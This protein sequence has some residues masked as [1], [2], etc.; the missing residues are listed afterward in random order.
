MKRRRLVAAGVG[1]CVV[2]WFALQLFGSLFLFLARHRCCGAA[3]GN[4]C[5]HGIGGVDQARPGVH[6]QIW[7]VF[8]SRACFF[9]QGDRGVRRSISKP[10]VDGVGLVF[11]TL[12]FRSLRR[13]PAYC[14]CI[15]L[16]GFANF[17]FRWRCAWVAD[18]FFFFFAPVLPTLP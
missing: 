6:P 13:P 8:V 5:R 15:S 11:S 3:F 17:R 18:V 10:L 7:Y 4:T 1:C 2:R 9:S 16:E 12:L 14:T